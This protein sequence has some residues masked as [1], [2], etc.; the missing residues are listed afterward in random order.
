[1][2]SPA[3][4]VLP[5]YHVNLTE[6]ER[7]SINHLYHFLGDFPIF[8]V[9]PESLQFEDLTYKRPGCR[10]LPFENKYF[11]SISAYSQ[12]LL[13][14]HFYQA[15]S[16]FEY[17]L[18]YQLDC[19]VFSDALMEFCTRGYDYI[20]APWFKDPENPNRGFSRTG[21]GGF[22]LRKVKTFL[23]VLE[24][25]RYATQQVSFWE[26]LF[27]P[28]PLDH[29]IPISKRFIKRLR[30]MREIRRGVKW[31]T[32]YYTLNEDIFW[33]DRAFFYL[34]E[35]NIAPI[36]ESLK[37]SFERFPRYCFE[38]NQNQLPFG[39]HAWNKWDADFWKPYL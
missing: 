3:A 12:L 6:D 30:V 38:K 20:G 1:M 35:I 32:D 27:K 9:V 7:V 11:A 34:P 5:T 8:L 4:I 13:S 23:S 25:P 2:L 39:C 19:L 26:D 24:S 17:I 33:S 16:D 10:I 18:I 36:Q 29:K 37:F 22:S 28:I 15:F 14:K 31:Y 21:N